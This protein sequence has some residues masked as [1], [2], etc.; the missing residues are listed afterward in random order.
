VAGEDFN[1][2]DNFEY[3]TESLGSISA[4]LEDLVKMAADK[5]K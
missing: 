5:W 4:D 3:Y 1:Y 2:V